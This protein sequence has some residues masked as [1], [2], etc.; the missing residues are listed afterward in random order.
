[1]YYK[2]IC[3]DVEK[4]KLNYKE[5][6]HEVCNEISKKR[7]SRFDVEIV[8]PL[9]KRDVT[10][11]FEVNGAEGVKLGING[12]RLKTEPDD[13]YQIYSPAMLLRK[14]D[15]F[16]PK[17][18]RSILVYFIYAAASEIFRDLCIKCFHD[19][20]P[21]VYDFSDY[22]NTIQLTEKLIMK[23]NVKFP[24]TKVDYESLVVAKNNKKL[25]KEVIMAY[26][27]IDTI[28]SHFSAKQD[29]N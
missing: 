22:K 8:S 1:M 10:I 27:I 21:A 26:E 25:S 24:F 9:N 20:N 29:S 7:V 28:S 23:K 15:I 18:H 13:T 4:N 14:N 16:D 11:N 2:F 19:V 5:V 17:V 12:I 6:I 3:D